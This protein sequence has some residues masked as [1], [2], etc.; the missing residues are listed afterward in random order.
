[1]DTL[2]EMRNDIY[3]RFKFIIDDYNE[4]KRQFQTYGRFLTAD[5]NEE[6]LLRDLENKNKI[7]IKNEII[8]NVCFFLQ[9]LKL[10]N[11]VILFV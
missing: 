5:D 9:S 1:M 4:Y 2:S 8:E 10:F 3:D 11:F 7:T 6:K